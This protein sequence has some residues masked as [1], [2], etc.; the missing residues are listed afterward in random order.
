MI[1]HKPFIHSLLLFKKPQTYGWISPAEV[2]TSA[3]QDVGFAAPVDPRGQFNDVY[4][5]EVFKYGRNSKLLSTNMYDVR[6]TD[7][8]A[9]K[10]TID[11]HRLIFREKRR[12]SRQWSFP[13]LGTFK[14]P[15]FLYRLVEVEP[16][17]F[18]L[19]D[20]L[21]LSSGLV[22]IGCAPSSHYQGWVDPEGSL[23]PRP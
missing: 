1:P 3:P 19:L 16:E 12:N 14:N 4:S 13:Y 22:L 9:L 2:A 6:W 11:G 10:L 8:D 20:E 21:F 23:A 18:D 15:D 17:P 5:F 7:N